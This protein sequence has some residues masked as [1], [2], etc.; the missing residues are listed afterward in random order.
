MQHSCELRL[1]STGIW[2]FSVIVILGD[3][4]EINMERS[5]HCMWMLYSH[6]IQLSGVDDHAAHSELHDWHPR[7]SST[8]LPHLFITVC[9]YN[10]YLRYSYTVWMNMQH[11]L[12]YMAD[13]Q[14][15]LSVLYPS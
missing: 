3:V 4:N 11:I 12:H 1:A 10:T 2:N 15:Y 9:R 5:Y 8:A 7:L 6:Q 13:S 14:V